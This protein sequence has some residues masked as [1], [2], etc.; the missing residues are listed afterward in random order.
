[1]TIRKVGDHVSSLFFQISGLFYTALIM[2]IYFGKKKLNTLENRIYIALVVD[3]MIT[4]LV[5]MAS[6]YVAIIDKGNFLVNPLCKLY[7]VMIVSWIMLFTYYVF[8]ISSK[9]NEGHVTIQDDSNYHYF[10]KVFFIF[11]CCFMIATLIIWIVPL[12]VYS[13]GKLMYTYGPGATISYSVAGVCILFWIINVFM[14]YRRMGSKKYLPVFAFIVLATIAIIIQSTWPNILLVTSVSAFIT[15]LT[16]FTIENPDIKMIE[17]LNLAKEQAEK[18]NRAKTDFLSN[19]SHE[20][21]TPL[22]AIV[23][24]SQALMEEDIPAQ[25]KEEVS[26]ILMSSNNLLEIVNGILDISKIEANKLEI[27]NTEYNSY[28][29]MKDIQSLINARIGDKPLELRTYIDSSMPPV[30]Y[31]DYVRIKQ[32]IIN[33]LTNAVKYTQKGFIEFKVDTVIQGEICRLIISV[34]DTGIGIKQEDISKLFQ[35]FERFELEKNITTEGTGLGLAITKS[36]VELMNGKIVVQSVY[37]KGSKFTVAIDQRIIPKTKEELEIAPEEE[38]DNF[39]AANSKVLIVDDNKINLKVAS[40]LLKDYLVTIELASSGQECIDKI[41]DGNHYDL[42]LLDDMMPKMT[43]TQTLQHLKNIIGFQTPVIALTANAITG[44]KEKYI[45]DGF[46]D[47]L[48][49]PIDRKDLHN[50]LK[51]YLKESN[52]PKTPQEEPTSPTLTRDISYLKENGFDVDHG[53]ELLNDLE[54]YEMTLNDFLEESKTRIPKMEEYKSVGDMSNYAILAHAMKSDAKYLGLNSLAEL[55][56]QHEM[57]G[58]E[59]RVEFV[60]DNYQQLIEELNQKLA[61]IKEYLK[62]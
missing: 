61:I 44:M 22:N 49:K 6:V 33:L 36:L 32:I 31:G 38:E 37:G 56:Y 53:I 47:Y 35:K 39:V 55:S 62:K 18:A 11:L 2:F 58:K 25:S 40:R 30:L 8:L 23:G 57:A 20:I 7:L 27:V 41:L 34:E 3:V 42:I 19:M 4:L 29:L 46:N 13:D 50:I 54:T 26:D 28:R 1:M 15:C 52:E 5:D 60:N 21:R 51:K 24:F 14:N 59:N 16:F 43:G 45:K 10:M 17:Q 9:R 48:A 12:Y